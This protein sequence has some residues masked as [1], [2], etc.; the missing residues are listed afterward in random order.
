[1]R[2][3]EFYQT[4]LPVKE[5]LEHY[6]TRELALLKSLQVA[7]TNQEGTGMAADLPP[8]AGTLPEEIFRQEELSCF[9]ALLNRFLVHH[10]RLKG[11]SLALHLFFKELENFSRLLEARKEQL[12]L[13]FMREAAAAAGRC[14][15]A[16]ARVLF[17]RQGPE[18]SRK[19]RL[20]PLK[21]FAAACRWDK[22]GL[23][24]ARPATFLRNTTRAGAGWP[25]PFVLVA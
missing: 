3:L 8:T 15:P 19:K 7:G 23:G 21:C 2:L 1:L 10:R 16:V 17:C 4:F 20:P 25:P 11:H 24:S 14:L 22:G 12:P 13:A 18:A 9:V 5:D 6:F